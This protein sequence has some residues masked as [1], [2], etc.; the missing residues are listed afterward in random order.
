M[1]CNEFSISANNFKLC[2]AAVAFKPRGHWVRHPSHPG[3]HSGRL[4]SAV[5]GRTAATSAV[6]LCGCLR[7]RHSNGR[8]PSAL[9][10][11]SKTPALADSARPLEFLGALMWPVH[12]V[13]LTGRLGSNRAGFFGDISSKQPRYIE[14][15][16]QVFWHPMEFCPEF[17]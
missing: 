13:S 1:R 15:S 6:S 8:R 3:G 9:G 7:A 14:R 12:R 4:G 17:F 5:Q 16:V 10:V 11:I 2:P